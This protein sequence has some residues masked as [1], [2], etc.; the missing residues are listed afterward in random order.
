MPWC[1]DRMAEVLAMM[2]DSA[3]CKKNSMLGAFVCIRAIKNHRLYPLPCQVLD[4]NRFGSF[5]S[6]IV[7][8][9]CCLPKQTATKST[10]W[11]HQ[12]EVTPGNAIKLNRTKT[13]TFHHISRLYGRTIWFS[14]H[15]NMMEYVASHSHSSAHL[16]CSN[17]GCRILPIDPVFMPTP[18]DGNRLPRGTDASKDQGCWLIESGLV[19]CLVIVFNKK[20]SE[21]AFPCFHLTLMGRCLGSK[22]WHILTSCEYPSYS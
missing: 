7:I 19:F 17:D 18:A 14:I 1:F 9:V 4:L 11:C 5:T 15:R 12:Y 6:A 21:N 16:V 2:S 8:P 3:I 10:R 13:H 22:A 20:R